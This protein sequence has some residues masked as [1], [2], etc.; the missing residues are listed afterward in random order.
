MGYLAEGFA[1]CLPCS[2]LLFHLLKCLCRTWDGTCLAT[3]ITCICC[4]GLTSISTGKVVCHLWLLNLMLCIYL[5][6][7]KQCLGILIHSPFAVG[8]FDLLSGQALPAFPNPFCFLCLKQINLWHSNY[9]WCLDDQQA[10]NFTL[11]CTCMFLVGHGCPQDLR[12]VEAT[13]SAGHGV[14]LVA[15]APPSQSTAG[16]I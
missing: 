5:L 7:S 8:C 13:A 2:A 6:G 9:S 11:T 15:A 16:C 1:C 10:C 14:R 12:Q 3:D 4:T